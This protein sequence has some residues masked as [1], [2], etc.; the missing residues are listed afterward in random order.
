MGTNSSGVNIRYIYI[1]LLQGVA[2]WRN[3]YRDFK[4]NN[5]TRTIYDEDRAIEDALKK[6]GIIFCGVDNMIHLIFESEEAYV[7]FKLK[8]I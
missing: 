1:P 7:F 8:W 3:F 4:N 6:D 2:P 5:P